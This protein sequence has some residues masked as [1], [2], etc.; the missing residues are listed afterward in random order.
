MRKLI[1]VNYILIISAGLHF[2]FSIWAILSSSIAICC[3][4]STN[5]GEA[6]RNAKQARVVAPT[7]ANGA[8][9]M[10]AS[11][12]GAADSVVLMPT[13]SG[14]YQEVRIPAGQK[15]TNA[16]Q[17]LISAGQVETY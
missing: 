6:S 15:P 13:A 7:G 10:V 11:W 5:G 1:V 3:G 14:R 4:N 8:D 16:G 12:N 9:G 17:I 2:I